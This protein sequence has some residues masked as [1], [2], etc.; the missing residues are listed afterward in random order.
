MPGAKYLVAL[1]SAFAIATSAALTIAYGVEDMRLGCMR[2]MPQMHS[3][4]GQPP[5]RQWR[6]DP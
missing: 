1:V 6:R 4:A 5:N 3:G 2:V